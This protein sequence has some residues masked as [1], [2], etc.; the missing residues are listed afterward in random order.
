M[1]EDTIQEHQSRQ[2]DTKVLRLV[3]AFVISSPSHSLDIDKGCS[4]VFCF[5]L[6]DVLSIEWIYII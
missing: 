4:R 1:L 6:F 5:S 2:V 3:P